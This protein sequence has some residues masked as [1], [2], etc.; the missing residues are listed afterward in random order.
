MARKASPRYRSA[1]SN[2]PPS[3]PLNGFA[4]SDLPPS[5][6]TVNARRTSSCTSAG[7]ASKSLRAAFSH[8]IGRVL[9]IS[10]MLTNLSTSVKHLQH[11]LRRVPSG[12]S[13]LA[14]L[15]FHDVK[16]WT[17]SQNNH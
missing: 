8:E 2:T 5:A 17:G 16:I 12:L 11:G 1:I 15:S 6:A 3:T 10:H 9:R 14:D 13:L 4:L 7:K